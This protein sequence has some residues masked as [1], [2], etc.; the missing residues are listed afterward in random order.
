[1]MSISRT[2]QF[3]HHVL[4]AVIRPLRVLWN[5]IIGFTFL[6]FAVIGT[7]RVIEGVRKFDGDANSLFHLLVSSVFV[8]AMAGFAVQ[9][10]W[11][12]RR[13]PK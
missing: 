3:L 7:P 8:L 4:P 1:M 11:R 5:Q 6:V 2:R 10:F 9:S 12:A 13:V